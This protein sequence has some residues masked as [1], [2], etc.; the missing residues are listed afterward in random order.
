MPEVLQGFRSERDFDQARKTLDS[1]AL[2]ELGGVDIAVQSAKNFR[3]LQGLGLT[4]HR[5]IGTLIA[6][7]CI[8]SGYALL[9]ADRDFD[10]F[11][12]NLGLKVAYSET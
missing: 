6:T 7:R 1:F 8:E 12:A 3:F 11:E 10:P 4:V 5:W 9:Q 2:I